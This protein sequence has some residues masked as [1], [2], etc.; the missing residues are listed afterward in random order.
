MRFYLGFSWETVKRHFLISNVSVGN[1][2]LYSTQHVAHELRVERACS[3]IHTLS[4]FNL[5]TAYSHYLHNVWLHMHG[6]SAV[7]TV[8][9]YVHECILYI[10]ES[11]IFHSFQEQVIHFISRHTIRIC[12]HFPHY[13]KNLMS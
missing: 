1:I 6:D 13:Q 8:M 12:T 3:N 4:A 7:K 2:T 9:W 10:P 5:V 11:I